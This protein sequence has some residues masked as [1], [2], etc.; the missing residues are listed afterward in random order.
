MKVG[1]R[2]DDEWKRPTSLSPTLDEE[3]EE[4][5]GAW[6]P[7]QGCDRE[8]KMMSQK[9]RVPR[10]I[11]RVSITLNEGTST[12]K[13]FYTQFMLWINPPPLHVAVLFHSFASEVTFKCK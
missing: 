7:Q 11:I 3:E 9:T 12:N 10:L 6:L 8:K 1:E 5:E 4:G 2:R 13:G